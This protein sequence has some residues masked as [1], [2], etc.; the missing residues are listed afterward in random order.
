MARPRSF[1]PDD[2]LEVAR[3]VFLRKGYQAASLDEITAA[4][5]IAKPSLYAA[6]GD[7]SALFLRVLDRYHDRILGWAERVLAQPGSARDAIR[8]WLTGFVPYCSGT[9]GARGCLSINSATEG[10]LDQAEVRKSIERYNRQLEQ[11][12]RARLH[13]DR[14][15]FR[16]GFD[17]DLTAHTIMVVH[18]GLMSLAHQGSDAKQVQAVI[19]Q[20]MTLLA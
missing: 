5:G 6:F 19:D 4:S 17:A 16:K 15:Q 11:L 14:A 8:Q 12:L 1:D 7:K 10:S 9:K 13:A 3:E 18:T 20:V 2:V